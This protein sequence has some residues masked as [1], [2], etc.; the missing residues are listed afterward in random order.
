[1]HGKINNAYYTRNEQ[2]TVTN[3]IN[4]LLKY[5]YHYIYLFLL[6]S[7]VSPKMEN[8]EYREAFHESSIQ[9]NF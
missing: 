5:L 3:K 8:I 2:E 1:M 6:I 4:I 9:F 7:S